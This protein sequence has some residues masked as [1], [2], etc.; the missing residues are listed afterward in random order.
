MNHQTEPF[1][2]ALVDGHLDGILTPDETA[3]LND[4]I[5]ADPANALVFSRMVRM[6]S[7][8]RDLAV[9]TTWVPD[10]P[11]TPA[12][13]RRRWWRLP[14]AC[15]LVV[16]VSMAAWLLFLQPVSAAR[17]LDRLIAANTVEAAGIDRTYRIRNLDEVPEAID[18][19]R[20][21]IDGATLQVRAPD[22]YVLVRLQ[23]D[24]SRWTT[25]SDGE[26]GWSVPPEG[27]GAVRVSRDPMRFRG[28][29]PGHQSG[30]PFANLP[31]DLAQLRVTYDLTLLS[32][33]PEGWKGI[34]ARKRSTWDRGPREVE[35]RFDPKTGTI[36]RMT[37]QGMPKARGGPDKVRV[38]LVGQNKVDTGYFGHDFHHATDRKVVVED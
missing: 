28:P 27:Q 16:A 5:R 13:P 14:Q 37:F 17:E 38:E 8:L 4:W 9:Q 1:P 35:I 22:N 11:A 6:H 20:P 3:R 23:P 29:V 26:T 30:I 31:A 21:P 19:K 33:S 36:Q 7:Q 24:G 10:T 32:P 2:A 15:A 34:L 12:K 25:G 18:P